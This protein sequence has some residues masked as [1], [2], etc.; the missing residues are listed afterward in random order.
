M[1]P[2]MSLRMPD[3]AESTRQY[4]RGAVMG[5]TVAE[6]FML[7]AFVLLMLM[8]LWRFEDRRQLEAA[9]QFIDLAPAEKKAVLATA[10]IFRDEGVDPAD[11][12]VREK[13]EGLLALGDAN[14]PREILATLAEASE[15]ERRKLEDL[16]RSDEWRQARQRTATERIAGQLQ[17]AAASQEAVTEALRRELGP[18][19]AGYGGTIQ[20]DG[21]LVFPDTVLFEVGKAE[22]TPALRSFLGSVCLPWIRTVEGSGASV[23]DLRVE[24]HASSEWTREASPEQAYLNNLALSQQRAHAVLSTCLEMIPGPEGEWARQRAM[25]VGYSSSHPVLTNGAEDPVKSRRVVFRV[26]FDLK[27]VIDGIQGVVDETESQDPKEAIF[28]PGGEQ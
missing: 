12:V 14:P 25:A 17:A 13:L 9:Q 15:P 23:S 1:E 27:E 18:L 2:V 22:I 11:P 3:P 20:P 21:S 28:A 8:L 6:A 16:I 19:V 5:L 10:E 26:D 7:L 4:R 24:G